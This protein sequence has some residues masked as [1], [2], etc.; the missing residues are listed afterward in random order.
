M[1]I[2]K[3]LRNNLEGDGKIVVLVLTVWFLLFICCYAIGDDA[4]FMVINHGLANVIIDFLVLRIFIP[5][6]LLFLLS[7][8]LM[9][10]VSRWRFTGLF[11][12]GSGVVSYF[13]GDVLKY[14]FKRPRPFEVLSARVFPELLAFSYSFPSTT[15]ALFFGISF[16]VLFDQHDS[17]LSWFLFLVSVLLGFSVIYV[18]VHFPCDVLFGV[19]LGLIF[20]LMFKLAKD[21]LVDKLRNFS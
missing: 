1:R 19:L 8:F 10:Y 6:F 12:L 11:S 15:S 14:V 2:L 5:L 4:L 18:G 7:P 20:A 3:A 13:V 21:R 16:F 17:K 9:L